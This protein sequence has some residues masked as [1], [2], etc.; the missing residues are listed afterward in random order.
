MKMSRFLAAGLAS[1]LGAGIASAQMVPIPLLTGPFDPGSTQATFNTLIRQIDAILAPLLPTGGGISIPPSTTG[2]GNGV[3]GL[4]GTAGANAGIQINPNGS[5]NIIL[6][7]DGDTGSLQFG[8]TSAFKAAR[9][10]SACPGTSKNVP[11]GVGQ[12]VTGHFIVQDWAGR[13]HGVPA[14]RVTPNG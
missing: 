7:G 9:G 8:N 13:S 5:G 10:F 3:I 14:C 4:D 2:S 1:M 6:F 11:L 12:T